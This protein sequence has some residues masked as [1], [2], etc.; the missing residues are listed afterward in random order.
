MLPGL[1]F[2]ARMGDAYRSDDVAG[3]RESLRDYRRW[4]SDN[5]PRALAHARRERLFN[6]YDPFYKSLGNLYTQA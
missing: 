4:L 1:G 5:A 3:F 2:F 6:Q